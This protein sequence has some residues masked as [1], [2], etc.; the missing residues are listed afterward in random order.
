MRSNILIDKAK[1]VDVV[2]AMYNLIEYSDNYSKTSESFGT[3]LQRWPKWWITRSEWFKYKTKIRGKTSAVGNTKNVKTAMSW[4]YLSN[5]WR[6]IEMPLINYET[7]LILT[8]SADCVISSV[9]GETEFIF[10]S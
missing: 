7:N 10:L 9:T 4:K 8:W 5:F 1:Y 2:M 6:T 3:I